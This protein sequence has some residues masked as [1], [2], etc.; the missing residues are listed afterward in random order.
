MSGAISLLPLY[1]FMTWPETAL[2]L[3]L[4]SFIVGIFQTKTLKHYDVVEFTVVSLMCRAQ[5]LL[6]CLPR[7]VGL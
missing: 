1:P 2:P 4:P 5:R 3:P 6:P 7:T